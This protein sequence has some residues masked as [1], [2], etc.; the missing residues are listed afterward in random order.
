MWSTVEDGVPKTHD[1]LSLGLPTSP[2]IPLPT[3]RLRTCLTISQSI[4]Q[5]SLKF[6]FKIVTYIST[7]CPSQ[8]PTFDRWPRD[9]TCVRHGNVGDH[10]QFCPTSEIWCVTSTRRSETGRDEMIL[11]S[12]RQMVYPRCTLP[13]RQGVSSQVST[14]TNLAVT[15]WTTMS[16]CRVLRKL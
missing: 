15:G 10:L 11:G 7:A 9:C 8:V 12:L 4:S 5:Q 3:R 1:S 2:P 6:I 13:P 14:A 16:L